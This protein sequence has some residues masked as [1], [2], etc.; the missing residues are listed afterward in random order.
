MSLQADAAYLAILHRG[1]KTRR[2]GAQPCQT[3]HTASYDR[4]GE[5]MRAEGVRPALHPHVGTWVET[6]RE[7]R[8]VLDAVEPD[9][10]CA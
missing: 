8:A 1:S 2:P 9:S 4:I 6:E 10:L 5:A 7:C 3:P